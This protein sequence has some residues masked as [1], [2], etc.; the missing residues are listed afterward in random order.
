MSVHEYW[1]LCAETS[2]RLATVSFPLL[3]VYSPRR[4]TYR[5]LLLRLINPFPCALPN[6][7]A[8]ILGCREQ[9][10]NHTWSQFAVHCTLS[11]C[12]SFLQSL[13]T[14]SQGSRNQAGQVAAQK[15]HALKMPKQEQPGDLS[16]SPRTA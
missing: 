1:L 6:K 14:S 4:L 10:R 3:D 16:R 12:L 13:A 2:K 11:L 5:D 9:Q 7:R 15:K 8:E